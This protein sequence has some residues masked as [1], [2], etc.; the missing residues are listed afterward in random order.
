LLLVPTGRNRGN[1][2][3]AALALALIALLA[4]PALA[5][6]VT[7]K[8]DTTLDEADQTSGTGTCETATGKC[9]LR[10]AI[11]TSNANPATA[12]GVNEITFDTT[13]VFGGAK[14]ASTITLLSELPEILQP[15]EIVGGECPT[16]IGEGPCVEVDG[17][18]ASPPSVFHVVADETTISGIAIEGGE[19]GVE[20]SA[21][22]TGF[23]AVGDWFG[24]ELTSGG[25]TGGGSEEAGIYLNQGADDA[26]IGGSEPEERDVFVRSRAGVVVRGASGTVIR[27]NYFGVEPE[28]PAFSGLPA[29]LTVG[30]QIGDDDETTTAAEHTEI[31]GVL[32]GS[33]AASAACDGPCNVIATSQGTGI[34]LGGSV[35]R[36]IGT[37]SGPTRIRGNYIGLGPNGSTTFGETEFGVFGAPQGGSGSTDG[38]DGLTVGGIGP[39]EAN[40]FVGAMSSIFLL[41]AEK[42]QI[43]GN[44]IG[45]AAG[46]IVSDAPELSGIDLDSEGATE[47]AVIFGNRIN[48]EGADG[49]ENKFAGANIYGNEI[50]G[51]SY[52]IVLSG[53]DPGLPNSVTFNKVIDADGYG[54]R[55]AN[56]SNLVAGNTV[57]DAGRVGI[58]TFEPAEHN[59]IGGDEPGEANVIERTGESSGSGEGAIVIGGRANSVNEVAGNEGAM[60]EGPFIDLQRE[61]PPEGP[62]NHGIPAPA[63]TSRQSSATG[64]GAQAG[65]TIRVFRKVSPEEGELG[66]LIGK[67]VADSAGNWTAAFGEKVPVGTLIAATQTSSDGGTSKVSAP[68]S[69]TADP[70]GGGGSGESGGSSS[71][72]PETNNPPGSTPPAKTAPDTKITKK[73]KKSSKA[74]TATFKFKAVPAAGVSFECKLDRAK[75][76]KCKSPKTYKKLKPGKHTFQVRAVAAGLKDPT[77]AKF[78]FTVKP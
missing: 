13:N 54:I 23:K 16:A 58:V 7:P 11:E 35:S 32:T 76:A 8:V 50:I 15:V 24:V 28:P 46:H 27:G 73:P 21:G 2:L 9:S 72:P 75:W 67:A 4:I 55:I 69:A 66:P 53:S 52:G 44:E 78:S 41:G 48:A 45:Y 56:S 64:S 25:G 61:E 29:L 31:G 60:N 68:V 30:V 10:A 17:T 34:E 33:E 77:P 12:P 63:L 14:P 37:A 43:S 65:A 20:V 74:T 62:P 19:N 71:Q 5:S 42:P 49:I 1:R 22:R 70:S 51:P 18:V 36:H 6:A 47:S 39:T 3:L 59:R 38:P 26:V 57:L 40:Y